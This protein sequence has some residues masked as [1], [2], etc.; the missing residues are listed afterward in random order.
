MRGER[1][2]QPAEHER[3]RLEPLDRPLEIKR[4]LYL[5]D[6]RIRYAAEPTLDPTAVYFKS[7]SLYSCGGSGPCGKYFGNSKNYMNSIAIVEYD[8]GGGKQLRYIVALLSNVLGRN[9]RR[10]RRW[11]SASTT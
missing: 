5:T 6:I 9:S 3:Q 11:R 2:D 10:T 4:L 1:L 8:A 7:G